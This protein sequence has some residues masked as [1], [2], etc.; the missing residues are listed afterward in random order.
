M[1]SNQLELVLVVHFSKTRNILAKLSLHKIS[2]T[3]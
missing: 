2:L 1:E 3:N